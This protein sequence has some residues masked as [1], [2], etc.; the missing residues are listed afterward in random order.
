MCSL[1]GTSVLCRLDPHCCSSIEV[2]TSMSTSAGSIPKKGLVGKPGLG[3]LSSGPGRGEMVIPPVSGESNSCMWNSSTHS[4]NLHFQISIAVNPVIMYPDM[5]G[6][7]ETPHLSASRCRPLCTAP[8]LPLGNTIATPPCSGVHQLAVEKC[9]VQ[10]SA[11][12]TCTPALYA[13]QQYVSGA[14]SKIIH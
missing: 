9:I 2:L 12:K 14:G 3:G 4:P 6:S 8:H 5:P 7:S 13:L 1:D 10:S 11:R